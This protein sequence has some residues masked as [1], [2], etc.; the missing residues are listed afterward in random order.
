MRKKVQH[1]RGRNNVWAEGADFSVEKWGCMW[2]WT[3]TS[4]HEMYQKL[5]TIE[6]IWIKK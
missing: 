3:C 5:R 6:S 4:Y 1:G 2:F